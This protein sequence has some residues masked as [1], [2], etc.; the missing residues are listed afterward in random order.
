MKRFVL[1]V[2]AVMIS[3]A[4]EAGD[5]AALFRSYS[6]KEGVTAV[7][8][9]RKSFNLMKPFLGL[10]KET[11]RLFNALNLQRMDM[12]EIDGKSSS[13]DRGKI[14][15]ELSDL[16]A[17]S[18]Y[19]SIRNLSDVDIEENSDFLFRIEGER[20]VD[21]VIYAMKGDGLVAMKVSCDAE[22]SR[23]KAALDDKRSD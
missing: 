9:T 11:K 4:A 2:C 17:D 19:V 6:E 15:A 14:L 23:I 21:V 5:A 16:C 1:L 18:L 20:I 13:V 3:C 12:L 8:L 7:T 22:L 10:D